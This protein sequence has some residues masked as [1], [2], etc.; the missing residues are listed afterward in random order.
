MNEQE[1]W[2][3]KEHFYKKKNFPGVIGCIDG[4]HIQIV[5]LGVRERSKYYN[6]KGFCSLSTTV[7][8]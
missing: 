8:L 1:K 2:E 7:V 3:I 4:T 6:R 5:A